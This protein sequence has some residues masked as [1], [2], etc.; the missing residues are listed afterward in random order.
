MNGMERK[1]GKTQ[2]EVSL[3]AN[4]KLHHNNYKMIRLA[5]SCSKLSEYFA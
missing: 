1:A 5:H 2:K 3:G 4:R